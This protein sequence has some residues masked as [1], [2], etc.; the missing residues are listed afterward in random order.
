MHHAFQL[1]EVVSLIAV[2]VAVTERADLVK[3]AR[4]CK[5]LA[6]P[7]LDTLW[8]NYQH[9][10]LPLIT[11]LPRDCFFLEDDCFESLLV[12]MFDEV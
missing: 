7:C 4:A 8:S 10:F 12:S 2:Q 1:D 11:C 5:T 3:L 9:D 6:K